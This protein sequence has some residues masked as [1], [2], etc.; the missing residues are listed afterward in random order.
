MNK[1]CGFAISLSDVAE[2]YVRMNNDCGFANRF[3]IL[4]F[5][6]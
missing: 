6:H 3:V 1:D 5:L 2:T 4:T